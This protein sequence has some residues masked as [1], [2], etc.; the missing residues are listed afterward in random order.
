MEEARLKTEREAEEARKPNIQEAFDSYV[1]AVRSDRKT[2]TLVGVNSTIKRAVKFFGNKKMELITDYDC[3]DYIDYPIDESG[4]ATSTIRKHYST[5]AAFLKWCFEEKLIPEYPMKKIKKPA[6]NSS[7]KKIE[8]FTVDELK[9]IIEC[10]PNEDL[11]W[12][13]LI[14]C[15]IDTG[16]RRGEIVAL[17][18]TDI[19][20]LSGRVEIFNNAQ[21]AEGIGVYE[22]TTKSGKSR[23]I[24]LNEQTIAAL[25]KWKK[26]QK[27]VITGQN[28]STP[29]YVFTHI[30]GKRISPQAPTAHLRRFGERYEIKGCHPHKFRHS[31]A[32]YMIRNGVDIK[33]ISEKLG[34]SSIEIT[35]KLYVHS[36]EETQ[37]A[38]NKKYSDILWN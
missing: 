16:A 26:L 18:W 13:T 17:R 1:K 2:N 15:F 32:T 29:E 3:Q 31:M 33:T 22:T 4:L 19:D 6:D 35:L 28:K 20:L 38:A 30:D 27:E 34:H 9:K 10:A 24:Y 21:Y 25:K 11:M 36:D 37:K 5:L 14:F 23:V 7:N 8:V 12:M